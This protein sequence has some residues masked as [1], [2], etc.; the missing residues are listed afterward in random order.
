MVFFG[1]DKITFQLQENIF[2]ECNFPKI[3]LHV[4]VCDSENYM[5]NIFGNYFLGILIS[6]T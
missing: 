6:V 1:L 2:L 4:F 3:T 5:E